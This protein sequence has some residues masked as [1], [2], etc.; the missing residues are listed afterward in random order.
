M[1][2]QI[3][4]KQI[5]ILLAI[6]LAFLGMARAQDEI[7][8]RGHPDSSRWTP[9]FAPGLVNADFPKGVWWETN[10]M[11]TSSRDEGLWTKRVYTNFILD[12][13][14]KLEPASNSGVFLYCNDPANWITNHLE[15]QIL[16]DHNSK[17]AGIPPNWRCA[18]VFGRL[19][20]CK[21]VT[22]P[23]GEWSRMTITCRD[24][25]LWVVLNGELVTTMDR[26]KWTSV[27]KNPDG[28]DAPSFLTTRL[29][30]LRDGR[31]GLQGAHGGIPSWFRNIRI[32]EL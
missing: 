4:V 12:L 13:E 10:G 27:A 14:F 17:W 32:K 25:M 30:S 1:K 21:D 9:L 11:L 15:V 18:G 7:P 31:I 20:P 26:S 3:S 5:M 29:S 2:M 24:N 22:K 19:A 28:T 6:Q 16:D 23:P 8:P